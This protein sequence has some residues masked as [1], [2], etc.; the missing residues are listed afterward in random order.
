MTCLRRVT[1]RSGV[2]DFSQGDTKAIG[3]YSRNFS[4]IPFTQGMVLR[5][6]AFQDTGVNARLADRNNDMVESGRHGQPSTTDRSTCTDQPPVC[7]PSMGAE[8]LSEVFRS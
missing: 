6:N 5:V 3:V 2:I 1:R 4:P 8:N 7:A